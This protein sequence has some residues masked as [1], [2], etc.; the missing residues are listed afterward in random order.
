MTPRLKEIYFKEIQPSLK[1][2]FGFKNIYMGPKLQK[3]VL[4]IGDIKLQK[5]NF[6]IQFL[7]GDSMMKFN[8]QMELVFDTE[9]NRRK[10]VASKEHAVAWPHA[11]GMAK[12][13]AWRGFDVVGTD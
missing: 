3:V 10:W 11:S 9:K 5:R 8:Y 2:K 12:K 6:Q 4:N 13:V 7:H 1:E